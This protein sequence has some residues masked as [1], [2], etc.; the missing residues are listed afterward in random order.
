M[1]RRDD[2]PLPRVE[3]DQVR[4]APKAPLSNAS[5]SESNWRGEL[6]PPCIFEKGRYTSACLVWAE[7]GLSKRAATRPPAWSGLSQDFSEE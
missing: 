1:E 7:P 5:Q 6:L 3:F 2:A 4:G